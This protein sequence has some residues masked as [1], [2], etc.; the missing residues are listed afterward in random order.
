MNNKYTNKILS[1]IADIDLSWLNLEVSYFHE[2]IVRYLNDFS[3]RDM[4]IPLDVILTMDDVER[5]LVLG[6]FA[7]NQFVSSDI[8]RDLREQENLMVINLEN[9]FA[10]LKII[11]YSECNYKSIDIKIIS[12]I[13]YVVF[14]IAKKYNKECPVY[15]TI[16]LC[17]QKKFFPKKKS[18]LTERNVNSGCTF[19]SQSILIW[20]IED[21]YKVLTHEL[22]HYFSLDY[23]CNYCAIDEAIAKMFNVK[24]ANSCNESYTEA[25]AT[26]LYSTV[27]AYYHK[28]NYYKIIA[29]E[30]KFTLFQSSKIMAYFGCEEIFDK[31]EINQ[32]TS[33]MSYYFLK[34]VLLAN[35]NNFIKFIE[36]YG[37]DISHNVDA[38]KMFLLDLMNNFSQDLS[39]N[40][41]FLLKQKNLI[42]ASF[43]GKTLKMSCY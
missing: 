32:T 9:H 24:G 25:L 18:I 31:T 5:K 3:D 26:I 2:K 40:V 8:I 42:N 29:N 27:L 20:R 11:A 37:P 22:I 34:L 36:D 7:K 12:Y 28:R 41:N 13:L 1:G 16:F 19:P 30:I 15:C 23:H 43:L 38:Y 17:A 4:L 14:N 10:K 35:H 39:Y 21:V 6:S 33:V